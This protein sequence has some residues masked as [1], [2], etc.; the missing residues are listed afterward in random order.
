MVNFQEIRSW[1]E[2]GGVLVGEVRQNTPNT[3]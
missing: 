3:P 1:I 2:D